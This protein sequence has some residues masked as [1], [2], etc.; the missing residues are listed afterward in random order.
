MIGTWEDV[1]GEYDAG[2]ENHPCKTELSD[3]LRIDPTAPQCWYYTK[4]VY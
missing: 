4:H 2:S 3:Q 1:L